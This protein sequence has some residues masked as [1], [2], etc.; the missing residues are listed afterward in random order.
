MIN[1]NQS[2]IREAYSNHAH[3]FSEKV[4]NHKQATTLMALI[5]YL[6]TIIILLPAI[7]IVLFRVLGKDHRWIVFLMALILLTIYFYLNEKK[8]YLYN[9]HYKFRDNIML[10]IG[11]AIILIFQGHIHI[12]TDTF[13]FL[14]VFV[15][16]IFCLP[17]FIT[18]QSIIDELKQFHSSDL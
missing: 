5:G 4:P 10:F 6:N 9:A 2:A 7:S 15:G 12:D 16:A 8:F 1:S 13:N 3:N 11:I 18:N 14:A 17:T